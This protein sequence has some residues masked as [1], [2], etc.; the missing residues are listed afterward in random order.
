[1]QLYYSL[2]EKEFTEICEEAILYFTQEVEPDTSYVVGE[3]VFFDSPGFE[4]DR[5]ANYKVELTESDRKFEIKFR[6]HADR[7]VLTI[8]PKEVWQTRE[9][10]APCTVYKDK[11]KA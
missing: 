2:D 4:L 1:M 11:D 6:Y 5:V 9:V 10:T 8:Q 3:P 7:D